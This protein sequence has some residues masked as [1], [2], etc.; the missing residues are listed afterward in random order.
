MHTVRRAVQSNYLPQSSTAGR[1][2][3][4]MIRSSTPSVRLHGSC[5]SLLSQ[6][7]MNI[8][9]LEKIYAQQ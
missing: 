2:T 4:T 1:V 5:Q 7:F 9:S 6:I 3:L 8:G